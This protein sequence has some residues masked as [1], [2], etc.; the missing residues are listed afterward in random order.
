VFEADMYP[1]TINLRKMAQG[2]QFIIVVAAVLL[3]EVVALIQA[4]DRRTQSTRLMYS[5][6]RFLKTCHLIEVAEAL[7]ALEVVVA[8]LVVVLRAVMPSSRRGFLNINALNYP[9]LF[10]R[11]SIQLPPPF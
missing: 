5:R 4:I 2:H 8:E 3:D 6:F 11:N 10:F 9:T 7:A 1:I